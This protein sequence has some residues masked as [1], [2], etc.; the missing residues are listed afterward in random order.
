MLVVRDAWQTHSWVWTPKKW[1][2]PEEFHVALPNRLTVGEATKATIVAALVI[3][4]IARIAH[5][6]LIRVFASTRGCVWAK[7]SADSSS[8][9]LRSILINSFNRHLLYFF[10][11][12]MATRFLWWACHWRHR[13]CSGNTILLIHLIRYPCSV[14]T[15]NPSTTRLH[16]KRMSHG[17]L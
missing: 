7:I 2:N 12:L 8:Y 5:S 14:W 16:W 11:H 3:R 9:S 13:G 4:E 6:V 17:D 15:G 1:G 10:E